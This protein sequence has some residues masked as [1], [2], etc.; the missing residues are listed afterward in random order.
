MMRV[1]N[2]AVGDKTARIG[3]RYIYTSFVFFI[4]AGLLALV[5]RVQ[6]SQAAH[7]EQR[8]LATLE[9][10]EAGWAGSQRRDPANDPP[11]TI[12]TSQ[13]RGGGRQS[14][15][16]DLL[17]RDHIHSMSSPMAVLALRTL[18]VFVQ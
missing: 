9:A 14:T 2:S 6:L 7:R 4:V 11:Q 15:R 13:Q 16:P 17:G 10:H 5:M 12:L 3:L 18:A 1:P 8:Q